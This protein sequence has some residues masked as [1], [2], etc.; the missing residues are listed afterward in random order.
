MDAYQLV[1]QIAQPRIAN[2]VDPNY[3]IVAKAPVRYLPGDVEWMA[4]V[5]GRL[6]K[7]ATSILGARKGLVPSSSAGTEEHPVS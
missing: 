2:V 7:L 4:G 3:T 5:H 6:R 1:S